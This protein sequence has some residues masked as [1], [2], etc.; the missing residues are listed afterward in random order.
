MVI[1]HYVI[2]ESLRLTSQTRSFFTKITRT[3]KH[4]FK[5]HVTE[6]FAAQITEVWICSTRYNYV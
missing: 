1:N 5:H 6:H 3:W 4:A 2:Q